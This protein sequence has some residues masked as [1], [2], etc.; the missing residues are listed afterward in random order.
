MSHWLI[1][2]ILLPLLCGTL[3]VALAKRSPAVQRGVSAIATTA[4]LPIAIGLLITAADG[5]YRV[6]EVGDWPVPFGIVLVLDRLSALLLLI[7]AVVASCSLL[8]AMRGADME[9]R[10]F[11]ALFQFQLMG[12]NGAF[13]T[14]DLF[15]LFVF[16]EVLLIASYSLLL[17]GGGA[18]RT[19]A[20]FHYVVLNLIGSTLFLVAV[21]V[22]YGLLGTLN[23]ADL[24]MRIS[25][26]PVGDAALL[27]A[28]GLLLL[29]VFALK[30][31]L[32][33]LYFWLPGAY[34]AVS[35]PVAALF[36][37]MTKV[38]IYAI[39]RVFTLVFGPQAGVAADLGAPWIWPLAL[40]TL[41]AA[42]LA[43]LAS[44]SLRSLIAYLIIVS[45]GML[46]TAVGLFTASGLS[47]ALFYMIHTTT[48]TAG[49]FLLADM[50][51]T[52]RGGMDDRLEPAPPVA[53]PLLLGVLFFIG[54]VAI[55]GLPPLSGFVGKLMILLASRGDPAVAWIW[56]VVL[57]ASLLSL[58]ALS[59]AGSMVFWKTR[60]PIAGSDT[61]VTS[62]GLLSKMPAIV[63]LSFSVLL[64]MSGK[65]VT[66]FTSATAEQI[67]NPRNYIEGVLGVPAALQTGARR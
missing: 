31:A 15:N 17:H 62:A 16:F 20:G 29:V 4:S 30:A 37:I 65:P 47:A 56:S 55:V 40:A 50:I 9:G 27:R 13:L 48:I 11:H 8:Y 23:M 26:A 46:L 59:R 43:V 58:I 64:V 7:T 52:Q 53:Q 38:G 22:L 63:L 51:G 3:L 39:I 54:A 41:L 18:S 14:G 61:K 5:N 67:A 44:S 24:A 34:D 36:A 49:L 25:D 66:V 45:I 21:G 60:G 57:V 42:A 32:L 2:P 35:A 28:G 6:Y 19:R 1:A 12:L 10:N 33:P